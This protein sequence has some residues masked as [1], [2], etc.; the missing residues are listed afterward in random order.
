MK[1]LVTGC[2]GFIGSH[3][4]EA[5]LKRGDSIVGIDNINDYYSIQQKENNLEILKEQ[6]DFVFHKEDIRNYSGLKEIFE[7]EKPDKVIHLAARAGVRPSIEQPLLY[8]E[9]NVKGTF[10]LL[11]LA[12]DYKVKNFVFASSSS[13]YGNQKKI[14]FSETDDVNN[15]I[16]PYAATKKTGELICHTYHHLYNINV[17]CLRF[18]TVYGPRGR[19]D[20]APYMFTESILKGEP[21]TRFGDGTTKRD[22]TYVSDI[23]QGVIAA[24]D[25]ELEYEIINLGNN[26]PVM[27]NDFIQVIENATGKKAVIKEMPMQPGDVD[28]TY[29]DITK[30]NKLLGY[31]PTT[32]IEAGMKKFVEWYR[33]NC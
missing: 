15:P 1:I 11:D 14:P 4:S 30:A 27:L 20:M 12:K 6:K 32:S 17:T 22:Y 19:P 21:I 13:V 25:K 9:V 18:F 3:V 28:I 16:S 2:A 5:L 33:K 23:V 26:Q 8:E 24:N 7:K 10:N 29:A 31:K